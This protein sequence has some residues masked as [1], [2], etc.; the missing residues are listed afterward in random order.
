[1]SATK[2]RLGGVHDEGVG[3]APDGNF[4]GECCNIDCSKC[5]VWHQEYERQVRELIGPHLF[6]SYAYTDGGAS[7]YSSMIFIDQLG[8][9]LIAHIDNRF[10]LKY[11]HEM[12][13]TVSTGMAGPLVDFPNQSKA[14][15]QFG[16]FLGRMK[17]IVL[18]LKGAMIYG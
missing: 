8:I 4:C 18:R 10:E 15:G 1:M 12:F 6:G 14:Y 13:A 7:E 16:T 5:G 11:Q 17:V 3:W 2:D 9:N